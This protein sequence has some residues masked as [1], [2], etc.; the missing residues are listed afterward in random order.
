ML[1]TRKLG[2]RIRTLLHRSQVEEDLTDELNDYLAHEIER[3]I[4]SGS[5]QEEARR[6]AISSLRGTERLKEECRDARGVRWLEE[7]AKNLHFALRTMRRAPV[8][9]GTVIAV[10]ALC[11]GANTAIFSVVDTVLFRPLPFPHQDR[12]VLLTEGIP[13]LGFAV[14][15]FACADYLFLAVHNR[16]FE[17]TGAFRTESYEILG[18]GQPRRAHGALITA[19]LFHVLHV[20]PALGRSFTQKEDDESKAVVVLNYGFARSTYGEP[21]RALGRT[22]HLNRKPYTVIGV[23]PQGFTFPLRGLRFHCEPAAFFVPVSW[24]TQDREETI[25]NFNF[26][27]IARLRP[28]ITVPQAASDVQRLLKELQATYSPELRKVLAQI[29][30]FSL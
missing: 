20:A 25:S 13:S 18:A 8:F 17:A 15:P 23:M 12:L 22:I 6:R 30:N 28:N 19:S 7:I 2:L 21:G 4:A 5:S 1:W 26:S 3:E 24:T 11:I 10:L 29:P 14:M 9:A 16:A 27:T